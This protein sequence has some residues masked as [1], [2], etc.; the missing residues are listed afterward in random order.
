[1]ANAPLIVTGLQWVITMIPVPMQYTTTSD[2]VRIACISLGDGP[3]LVFAS[4]IFG[5]AQGYRIGWPHL[6]DVTDSL[7]GL[8][9]RVIRFDHRGMGSSDRD[10]QDLSLE[11]R[12]RDLAAVVTQL[13][14]SRFALAGLD[15]GAAT[16]VAYAVQHQSRVSRLVLLSPWASG[17]RY[18]RIPELRAGYSAEAAEDRERRVFANLLLSVATGFRDADLARQGAER[19]LQSTS[20]EALSAFNA[21]N[22][23]IDI[24]PLLPQV[25]VPTL[26]THE[27]AFPF[28][29]LELCQEVA[30]GIRGAQFMIIG[31][32]SIAGRVHRET[33]AAIDRFLRSDSASGAAPARA[34]DGSPTAAAAPNGLTA[35]EL[36]VLRLVAAGSTNKEIS[37]ELGVAVA[38]VERHLVNVYT[39]IGARGRADA[40]AYALRHRLDTPGV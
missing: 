20:A 22:E 40:V 12:V 8:G 23:H 19:I 38:T 10:V 6:R 24:T 1:M 36:Q 37:S 35:R 3:P 31:D 14:L 34:Y 21:A 15:I 2:G 18:L 27:P 28:G 30:T 5:D 11:G 9:W 26:V 13:G 7:V 33:V 32:N 29:S 25:N 16:A 17:A 4:N 39:K